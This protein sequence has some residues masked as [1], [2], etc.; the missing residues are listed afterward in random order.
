M[1]YVLGFD[2]GGTKTECVLMEETGAILARSRSGASNAVNLGANAAAA[3]LAEAGKEALRS[4]TKSPCDVAYILAGISGAGEP[5]ARAEIQANLKPVF[6]KA[7]IV[8]ASDL[9]LS[10]AATGEIPSLVVIAGTGSAVLGRTSPLELARAGGFGPI[11][12]DAGSANDIGRKTVARCFQKFLNKERFLLTDEICRTFDCTWPQFV[13][14][15]REQPTVIFPKVFPIVAKAAESGD[16][17][18]RALLSMA[19]ANLVEQVREVVDHLQL[20]DS[21][22]FLAK[23]GGVFDGSPFLSEQFDLLLGQMVHNARPGPLPRPV[24]ES[25][26]ML[27]RGALTSPLEIPES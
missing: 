14:L 4:A 3:A 27:A 17:S 7:T 19:A 11:I 10:L 22:F 25:A 8:V 23:T 24:A 12:G 1:R 20:Q 9:I 13:D 16:L 18:A 26:A 15:A 6:P 2:G 21:G 5:A